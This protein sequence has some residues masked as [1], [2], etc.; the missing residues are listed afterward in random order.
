MKKAW[1]YVLGALLAALGFFHFVLPP[2]VDDHANTTNA[3]PPSAPNQRALALHQG[4]WVADLHAD[5]LMWNRSLNERNER[6]HVDVPRLIEGGVALQGFTIVSQV[7]WDMNLESNSG[8]SDLTAL[9]FVAERW[10]PRTWT[11]LLE[12]ALYQ[13]ERL[14]EAA[15]DSGGKLRV[16]RTRGELAHYIDA[17]A[18][19]PRQTAGFLGIEGAQVLEGKLENVQRLFDAGF[20]MM[21]PSHFFDTEVG[22]SAHGEQKHGLLPFGRR[23]IAEME[24]LGM[25]V[26]L[27]HASAQTIDDVLA[28]AT[29]P[30]V[31]SH[32]GVLGTCDNPR[33]ISDAALD[34]TAAAGGVVGI[35]FFENATCGADLASIVRAIRYTVD[36]IGVDHVAL[37]S[38][39]DGFVETP[40]DASQMASITEALLGAGFSE[41]Q[42]RA[43]MGRNVQR[44]LS[45]TLPP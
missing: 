43:I 19:D 41:D 6:G 2:V 7:P 40:I 29:K 39:F 9:L 18:S 33:N 30:V 22:G 8:T 35:G 38:D 44:V 1:P 10:P 28:V 12:R 15:L 13:A 23:V 42:I 14:H 5:S 34:R 20:R 36:R 4:L 3:P 31:F 32:T 25:L 17:R 37:G 11:S 27:A 16:I 45:Q 24:R 21:A 26:D